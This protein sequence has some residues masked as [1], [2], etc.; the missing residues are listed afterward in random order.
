MRKFVPVLG[1]LII[2]T[3]IFS[4]SLN[5]A[6]ASPNFCKKAKTDLNLFKHKVESN[7]KDFIRIKKISGKYKAN[8]Q[9]ARTLNLEANRIY[10]L[11][12][13]ETF[14]KA[15]E[16]YEQGRITETE[17]EEAKEE[18]DIVISDIQDTLAYLRGYQRAAQQLVKIK[19]RSH[20]RLN[21]SLASLRAARD[22]VQK[23]SFQ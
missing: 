18:F 2:S 16:D 4:F 14:D 12:G 11:R 9:K 23:C 15:K 21:R 13:K 10:Y 20:L 3:A 7:H 6:E 17:F 5:S 19:K 22:L 1:L 8:Y